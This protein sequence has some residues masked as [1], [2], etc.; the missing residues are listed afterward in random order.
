MTIVAITG[1]AIGK[2][3]FTISCQMLQPSITA[4]SSISVG[5]CFKYAVRRSVL[6][7]IELAAYG[8]INAHFPLNPKKI[9]IL[10]TGNNKINGETDN[11]KIKNPY[12]KLFAFGCLNSILAITKELQNVIISSNT[13]DNIHTTKVFAY[14]CGKFNV[15]NACLKLSRLNAFG[16]ANGLDMISELDLNES[17]TIHKN[18]NTT[19]AVI[20]IIAAYIA[21]FF[22]FGTIPIH[23]FLL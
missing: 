11:P 18:G 21:I 16:I 5:S 9:L 23:L 14:N 13:T 15:S 17:N 19:I 12:N 10:Y 6:N 1:F 8:K 20:M 3:T 7:E 2:I 22:L 4:A